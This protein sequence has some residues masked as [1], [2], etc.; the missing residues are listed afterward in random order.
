MRI[1]VRQLVKSNIIHGH[2][3]I[4]FLHHLKIEIMELLSKKQG[5]YDEDLYL[6]EVSLIAWPAKSAEL[7]SKIS[8]ESETQ[9]VK[10]KVKFPRIVKLKS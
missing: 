5:K 2:Q 4:L 6:P 1:F 7:S 8:Y 3:S 9:N 10:G